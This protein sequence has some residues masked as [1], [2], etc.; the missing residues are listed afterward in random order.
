MELSAR[1]SGGVGEAAMM[2]ANPSGLALFDTCY[3]VDYHV[4]WAPHPR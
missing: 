4:E 1:D 2:A 3:D